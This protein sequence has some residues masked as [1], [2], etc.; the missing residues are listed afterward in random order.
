M[1]NFL[2]I[3]SKGRSIP[4]VASQGEKKNTLLAT[5]VSF[6]LNQKLYFYYFEVFENISFKY[7]WLEVEYI[8]L[9]CKNLKKHKYL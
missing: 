2:L 7:Y 8:I 9:L 4:I 6:F 1:P 5:V 3:F